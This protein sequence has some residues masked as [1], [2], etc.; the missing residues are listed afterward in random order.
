MPTKTKTL[1]PGRTEA[2]VLSQVLEV[3]RMHGIDASRQNTGAATNASGRLVMFGQAGNSDISGILPDGRRLDIEVKREGF[4]PN[5]LRGEKREHFERQLERL[6]KTNA[7]GGI[8]FWTDDAEELA[9]IILPEVLAGASVIEKG[10]E[11]LEINRK[12]AA[13]A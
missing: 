6:R 11:P 9:R 13:P 3:L 1:K 7:A 8:G 12:D 2:Q 4:Q 10:Y 5:K